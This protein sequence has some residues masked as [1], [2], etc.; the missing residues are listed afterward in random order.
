MTFEMFMELQKL[1][2]S[3]LLFWFMAI[4]LAV[5]IHCHKCWS[6]ETE[7]SHNGTNCFTYTIV[8]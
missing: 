3:S 6:V 8:E 2:C 1:L 4:S 5:L 7:N